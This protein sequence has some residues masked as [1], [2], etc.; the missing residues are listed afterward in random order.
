M[1]I[2]VC[3]FRTAS[4]QPSERRSARV[5]ARR[6]LRQWQRD[7]HRPAVTRKDANQDFPRSIQ[8]GEDGLRPGVENFSDVGVTHKSSL[9]PILANGES[10]RLSARL[11]KDLRRP[12]QRPGHCLRWHSCQSGG[13]LHSA[14]PGA[15]DGK[16][17][18]LARRRTSE[19][20]QHAGAGNLRANIVAYSL[21][22]RAG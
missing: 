6:A 3:V 18:R 16:Q 19:S 13:E 7:A 15:R 20:I 4:E 11:I 17:H 8:P 10:R 2:P 22:I 14:R 21:V 5:D 1:P 9:S 12:W